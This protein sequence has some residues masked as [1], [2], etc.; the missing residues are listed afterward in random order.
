MK[1][2]ITGTQSG[3]GLALKNHLCIDHEI[4]ELNRPY[5]DFD[6][7]DTLDKVDLSGADVLINNSGHGRGGGIGL[8]NHQ[9]EDWKSIIDVNLAG[10]IY[11]TQRF[12][13]QNHSGKIIFIT[14]KSIEKDL[15]GDSVYAASKSGLSTFIKCMREEL[16]DSH[17]VLV[18]IRPG[19]VKT[20]FAKNRCIHDE[21]FEFD[22]S[23]PHLVVDDM[24][25]AIDFVL[26]TDTMQTLTVSKNL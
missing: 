12:I 8:R 7:F 17:Y 18:E 11:L 22:I 6:N 16:A 23:R 3:I 19:R 5:C 15:G 25:R 24:I 1:I 10:P 9:I 2:A 13:K 26:Y 14:S 4:L 21:N 20:D